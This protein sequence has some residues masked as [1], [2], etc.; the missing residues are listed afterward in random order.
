LPPEFVTVEEAVKAI[1]DGATV[2]IDGFSI[3]GVPEAVLAGIESSF[4]R[5]G[6]PRSLTIVHA[7]GQ[8]NGSIGLEHLATEGLT[9]RVVGSHWGLMP[10]MSS[11]LADGPVEA[12]CLPQG[13]IAALY[14]AIAGG[15]PGV[16]TKVGLG[17][18]VDPAIEGGKVNRLARESAPDY[19][20]RLELDGQAL[21]LYVRFPIG[22]GLIRA[23]SVDECGNCS[24]E[25]EASV[26]DALSIAQAVH[27]SGGIVICQA[28]RRVAT[29]TI[30]PKQVSVPGNFIDAVVIASDPAR[31][32]RQIDSA[33]F[34]QRYLTA[35][36]LPS[37]SGMPSTSADSA[38]MAVGRRAVKFLRPGDIVN[39]GT[40]LPGDTVGP[41]LLE[42]MS[43]AS[44]TMTVESGTYGGIPAGGTDFGATVGPSAII[45]H[46]SQFDFYDGGGLDATFM[47]VG[48][49]D[50]HG[51]VNVS[52][53]GGRL[54]G[55]GGFIDITQNAKRIYF[56]FMLE[57]RH[58]KI[59]QSVSHLTFSAE[60]ALVSRTQVYYISEKAVFELRRK[61]L[62]LVEVAP[63][64]SVA[65][66]MK[67]IPFEVDVDLVLSPVQ[68]AN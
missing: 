37:V 42:N 39:V 26:L 6:H 15:R 9:R 68:P 4:R 60:Q 14:R 12:I 45:P 55:C 40:G 19:V 8:S 20:R 30:P 54:I 47:G 41:A 51:N 61:G 16:L 59:V 49:V 11:F 56:C 53:L 33:E 23:T 1:P 7:A 24:Q 5:R 50:R 22:V 3:M 32:H 10:K 18:F 31:E 43:V 57:G 21:L 46:S 38:R 35:S 27:N 58:R 62:C 64:H 65:E 13:Q 34:D 67:S 66:I 17:T 63:G 28:K 44:V 48:E 25:E 36:S 52:R 2:A 29:G